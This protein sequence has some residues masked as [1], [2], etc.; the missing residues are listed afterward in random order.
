MVEEKLA[1]RR[2]KWVFRKI[3]SQCF[4]DSGEATDWF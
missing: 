4:A 3:W 1:N 2:L